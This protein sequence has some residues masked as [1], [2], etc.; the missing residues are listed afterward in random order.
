MFGMM[1]GQTD[2]SSKIIEYN[3]SVGGERIYIPIADIIG[4]DLDMGSIQFIGYDGDELEAH[5]LMIYY[6]ASESIS[7]L[8]SHN[9][10]MEISPTDQG[11]V[12]GMSTYYFDSHI[13]YMGFKN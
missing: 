10:F 7:G 12:S 1:F 5:P 3:I 4:L 2:I 13:D 6:Y 9:S 11:I 8:N